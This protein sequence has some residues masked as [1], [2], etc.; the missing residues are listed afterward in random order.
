[1]ILVDASV[2]IDF[3]RKPDPRIR[4]IFVA[5]GAAICG[6]TLAEVLHGARNAA[7]YGKILGA[8]AALP[9]VPIGEALWEHVGRNL[10]QLRTRGVTVPFQ[11][12]VIATVAIDNDIEL[13]TRDQ[14]FG[15]IRQVLPALRLFAEPP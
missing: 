12:V 7:D 11:D 6:V 3:L 8:L 15:M 2:I 9:H 1:M 13:W 5:Q 14:Q 4:Q 10:F